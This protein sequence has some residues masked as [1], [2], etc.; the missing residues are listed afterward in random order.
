VRGPTLMDGYLDDVDLTSE[1]IR[2]GWLYTGDLGKL[3]AAG[4]LH[5]VGR[6]KDV[7]VT[8]G[9][10]NVYPQDVEHAFASVDAEE[11]SVFASHTLWPKRDLVSEHMVLVVRPKNEDRQTLLADMKKLNRKLADHKRVHTVLWWTDEFPRTASMKV[12]RQALAEEIGAKAA[13]SMGVSMHA[14]DA[15]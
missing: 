3:D 13:E 8:A 7:I 6:S 5:L 14:S 11:I 1:T 2:D 12:K 10:K 15:T 4:H 9:G